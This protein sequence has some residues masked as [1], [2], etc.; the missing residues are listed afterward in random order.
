ML[1]WF[2]AN[3]LI[4]DLPNIFVKYINILKLLFSEWE[5]AFEVIFIVCLI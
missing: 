3:N 1:K 5:S 2:I 4:I